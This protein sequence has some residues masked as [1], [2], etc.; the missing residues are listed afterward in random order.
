MD[1]PQ[2]Y[3][4]FVTSLRG[5]VVFLCGALRGITYCNAGSSE[6]RGGSTISPWTHTHMP[7]RPALYIIHLPTAQYP[8]VQMIIIF[9][10]M[11]S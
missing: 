9:G 5:G 4:Q 3:D 8:Y 7:R 10:P 11:T 1:I 6:R 2:L